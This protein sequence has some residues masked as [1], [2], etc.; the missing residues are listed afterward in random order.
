MF[1]ASFPELDFD[2][3]IDKFKL[4]DFNVDLGYDNHMF[5][6]LGG[7]VDH[8]ESPGYL[9]GYD[10]TRDPYCLSLVDMPRKVMWSTFFDFSFDFSLALT[11]RG[12]ILFFVLIFMFSHG[13][14]CKPRTVKFDKLLRA[15]TE[16]D[17][18]A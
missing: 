2:V 16:S 13:H 17:L 18:R 3:P 11:L 7:N 15:L 1:T 6:M 14:A 5:H 4:C 9:S 8:F 10:P 12:L